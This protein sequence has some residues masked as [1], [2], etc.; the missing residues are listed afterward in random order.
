VAAR[1][2]EA[3]EEKR[4]RESSEKLLYLF[5][6]HDI[7]RWLLKILCGLAFSGSLKLDRSVNLTIPRV[8]LEILYGY[9][10]FPGEWGIY[11]CNQIGHDCAGPLGI[12]TRA[13]S[14]HERM[15]GLGVYVCGY[16]ILLSMRGFPGRRFDDRSFVY[17]P[18][19]LY[20]HSR[21]FEKSVV[22]S[23]QGKSDGGTITSSIK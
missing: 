9:C 15:T 18:F 12:M 7:E 20:T 2:F 8:W 6:G 5:N 1:L 23:W 13:I 11:I 16:E 14:N 22:F 10:D 17:R 3:F 4:A 19:E 21:E